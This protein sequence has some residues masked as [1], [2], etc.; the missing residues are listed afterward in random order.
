MQQLPR[1]SINETRIFWAQQ[2]CLVRNVI[3][4]Q[5]YSPAKR[6]FRLDFPG[7]RFIRRLSAKKLEEPVNVPIAKHLLVSILSL[8][9]EVVD[10]SRI[11]FTGRKNTGRFL[12][13][14]SRAQMSSRKRKWNFP[15]LPP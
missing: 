12:F 9:T 8:E 10:Q 4:K 1:N 5:A 15:N 7:K 13:A 14:V 6:V 2:G 3:V 11:L